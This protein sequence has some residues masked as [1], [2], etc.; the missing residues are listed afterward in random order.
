M[1]LWLL[2]TDT[3]SFV[4]SNHPLVNRR[5]SVIGD[6]AATSIITVQEVFNGWVGRINGSKKLD[7]TIVLYGKLS[8]A[9]ELFK[10]VKILDF[11]SRAGA[12]LTALLQN[13]PQLN[14]NKLENDMRIAAI[15]LANNAIVVTRNQKD[16]AQVPGLN[17]VDWT[18]SG[19]E[20]QE[21]R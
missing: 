11:D 8:K 2:D 6:D 15:A 13:N 20:S 4:L 14:K 7:E 5:L 18:K 16:F 17:I 9:L 1:S 10:D 3:V 19:P 12:E 21:V